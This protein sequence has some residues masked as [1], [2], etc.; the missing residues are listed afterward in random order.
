MRS[1]DILT[2][3]WGGQPFTYEGKHYQIDE[4]TFAHQPPPPVQQPRVPI[5]VVGAW[6]WP[7]SMQRALKYDGILPQILDAD[8]KWAELKPE[9]VGEIKVF[10]DEN[11]DLESNFDI[12]VEG[13]SPGSDSVS[14]AEKVFPWADAGATWWI[15][16]MWTEKDPEKWRQRLRQG[17]PKK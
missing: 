7:K 16:S 12:I 15:E 3:L 6:G 11:R 14:A 5:W 10:V 1:L 8:K 13:T 2:G 4:F 17:P 9:H